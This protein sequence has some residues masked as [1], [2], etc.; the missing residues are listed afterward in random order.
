M[1][2]IFAL[3]FFSLIGFFAFTGFNIV[4]ISDESQTED[5]LDESLHVLLLISSKFDTFG[6][7]LDESLHV[8]MLISLKFDIF[9]DTLDANENAQ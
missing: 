9:G 7:T 3:I 1:I 6:G 4:N 2:L 8:V 5:T